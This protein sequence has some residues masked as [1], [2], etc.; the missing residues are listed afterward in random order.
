M[1]FSIKVDLILSNNR[2]EERHDLVLQPLQI[3]KYCG[4]RLNRVCQCLSGC[5]GDFVDVFPK[6]QEWEY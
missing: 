6:R 4:G 3:A 2:E 5:V 1:L